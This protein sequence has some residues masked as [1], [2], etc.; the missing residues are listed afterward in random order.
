LVDLTVALELAGW[1]H[2]VTK[3]T[4]KDWTANAKQ[5]E[6]KKKECSKEEENDHENEPA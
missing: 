2:L 6:E 5:E 1:F 4:I 3:I